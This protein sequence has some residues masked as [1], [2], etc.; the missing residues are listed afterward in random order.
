ME[1]LE[2]NPRDETENNNISQRI[3]HPA[4]CR[5]WTGTKQTDDVAFPHQTHQIKW[6]NFHH[7]SSVKGSKQQILFLESK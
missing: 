6:I 7:I 3:S 5:C 2:K 4:V 1:T